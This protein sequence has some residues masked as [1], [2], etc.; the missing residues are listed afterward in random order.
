VRKLAAEKIYTGL[1]T[2]EDY[3]K[4]IPGG[5]EDTYDAVMDLLSET[6]WVGPQKQLIANVKNQIYA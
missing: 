5:D 3:S 6:E 4:V 2:M 1:L